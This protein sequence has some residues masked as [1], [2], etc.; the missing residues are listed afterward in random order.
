MPSLRSTLIVTLV[1]ILL[2]TGLA[3]A[4]WSQPAPQLPFGGELRGI[5]RLRGFLVCTNCTLREARKNQPAL[6]RLYQFSQGQNR[7]VMK[8][9]WINERA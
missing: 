1:S 2:L 7:V 9:E 6:T 5:V 8:V 3:P 4:A